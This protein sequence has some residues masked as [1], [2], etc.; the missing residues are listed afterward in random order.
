M[1]QRKIAVVTG[2]RAEYGLLY[3]LIKAIHEDEALQLALIVTGM[4]LSPEFGFTVRE[5]EKDGFPIAKRVEMLL[6]SDSPIG[7]VKSVGL[8]CIGFADALAE[9][10]PDIMVVLGDRFEALAAAVS[11]L[12]LG[13]P[14]AHIH[15]G[16]I[17][18]GAVDDSIRHSITKMSAY[19][20]TASEAYRKRI[21]RMGESPERVFVTGAPGLDRLREMVFLT[22]EELE[23]KL[24]WKIR[25]PVA[26]VTFHPVTLEPGKAAAQVECLLD[27]IR[28]AGI[29]VIFTGANA[30]TEGRLIT[31]L[32]AEFCGEDPSRYR[33]FPNLG[34]LRYLSLMQVVDLM[35]GNSSSGI[36]E[37]PSFG[38]PVVNVGSRQA[39]RMTGTNVIQVP[40][41]REKIVAGIRLA[42]TDTFRT[43]A[44]QADNPYAQD[45]RAGW[46]IK[47]ILKYCELS[48]KTAMKGFYEGPID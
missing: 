33:F 10:R 47:E 4:H 20:F 34:Q 12:I 1:K 14:I 43:Q 28:E 8:G 41:E 36:I 5:I 9:I 46:R 11:A 44:R 6:S 13:I 15:G 7:V 21:I 24:D 38:L 23:Q 26:L 45:Y 42:L 39:G 3:S 17:T 19:H 27:A 48:P 29:S 25:H 32:L 2:T 31:T 37:A 18:A 22:K 40:V 30:D 16:E 35:I